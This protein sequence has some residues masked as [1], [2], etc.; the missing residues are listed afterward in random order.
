MDSPQQRAPTPLESLL[1]DMDRTYYVRVVPIHK[2]GKA[3][4]PSLPVEVTVN[5]SDSTISLNGNLQVKPPSAQ[6]LWYM[7]PNLNPYQTDVFSF[8]EDASYHWYYVEGDT[9]HLKGLHTYEKPVDED[10]SWWE[11]VGDFFGNIINFFSD[12]M[13]SAS[14]M[15]NGL[16]D[17]LVDVVANVLSYTVTFNLVKC[18]EIPQCKEVIRMGFDAVMLAYG[19]PPTLPTGPELMSLSEDYLVELGADQLGAGG[20]YDAYEDLPDEV[21]PQMK[22]GAKE[23]SQ[24]MVNA[25]KSGMDNAIKQAYCKNYTN[26]LHGFDNSQPPT[27]TFCNYKIPD[28]IFNSVH[29]A[30]VMVYVNNPNSQSSDRM[31]LDVKDSMGLFYGHAII[32]TLESGKSISVPVILKEDFSQFKKVNGGPCSDNEATISYLSGSLAQ[33]PCPVAEWMNK[34]YQTG[35][36][37]NNPKAQDTFTVSFSRPGSN[38]I[39]GLNDQSNGKYVPN[40]LY[41][42]VYPPGWQITTQGK[43][44][45]PDKWDPDMFDGGMLRNKP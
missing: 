7:Q 29:P 6:I 5:W 26:P 33:L 9:F 43:S 8:G 20:V 10:K 14:M 11:K 35:N 12:V 22:S 16:K 30:T 13:T 37:G 15:F 32:P 36:Y 21:K 2:G 18:D 24:Q 42:I 3:G 31:V 44:I 27:I 40:T 38:A 25:Q 41:K 34:W 39:Y 28:P 19:I 23:I 17:I 4:T 45:V 1:L